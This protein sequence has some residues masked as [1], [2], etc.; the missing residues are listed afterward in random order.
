MNLIYV[1]VFIPV[2]TIMVVVLIGD[3]GVGKSNLISRFANDSVGLRSKPTADVQLYTRF[4]KMG[5]QRVRLQMWDTAGIFH[6]Y[7]AITDRY[8]H[9]AVGA[10]LVYDVTNRKSFDVLERWF[11][12]YETTEMVVMLVGNKCDLTYRRQV[13]PKEGRACAA[14]HGLAFMETSA[15]ETTN[16]EKSFMLMLAEIY[17]KKSV[18]GL[19]NKN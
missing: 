11:D 1:H 6:R 7:T 15:F 14:K 2:L 8:Y 13:S 12:M 10:F 5:G 18:R 16:V 9:G 3:S 19:E 4:F 17:T